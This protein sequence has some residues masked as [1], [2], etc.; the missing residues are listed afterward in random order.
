[1]NR[2]SKRFGFVLVGVFLVA[3]LAFAQAGRGKAR[4]SGTV[5]DENGQPVEAAEV[6]IEFEKGGLVDKTTTNAKGEFYFLGLGTGQV[7]VTASAE[8]FLDASTNARISQLADG[9][10]NFVSL[11]LKED[12]ERKIRLKDAAALEELEKGNQLFGERKFDEALQVFQ[13]FAVNNPNVYQIHFNIGDTY[14]EKGEFAKAN[15]QYLA[16]QA[17]AKEK[18]DVVL[19]ARA[20]ASLGEVCLRQE[21]YKEAQEYFTQSIA[22]NPKDEILAY[23]VAEIFFGRNQTDK[24]IEYYQLA[25][26]IKPEWSEPY[27]KM[28]YAYLNKGDMKKA[29]EQLNEFLKRDPESPQAPVVKNLIETLTKTK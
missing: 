21:K 29:V 27:L 18:A 28:G 14:R 3:A 10:R 13:E 6:K 16:A 12:K 5:V 26:K 20:L 4:L 17:K 25:T 2:V 19:Q 8:G 1:M 22:L 7:I 11:V 23:N 9:A 15:E 24:A